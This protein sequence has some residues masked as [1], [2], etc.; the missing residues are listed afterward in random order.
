MTDY[1][2]IL[3]LKSLGFSERNIAQNCSCSRNTVSNV[4]KRA[5]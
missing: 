2:E 3:R 4:L 5:R 1:R